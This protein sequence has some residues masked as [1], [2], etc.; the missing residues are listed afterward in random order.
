MMNV[1]EPSLTF[2]IFIIYID[3]EA[4]KNCHVYG[5]PTGP[6]FWRRPLR[7]YQQ[8]LRYEHN[9]LERNRTPKYERYV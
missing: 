3:D 4:K 7:L 8:N 9:Y 6:I 2:R 1:T 5:Y